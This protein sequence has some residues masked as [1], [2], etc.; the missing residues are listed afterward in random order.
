MA[1]A[2]SGVEVTLGLRGKEKGRALYAETPLSSSE[3]VKTI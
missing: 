1:V 2:G 3:A